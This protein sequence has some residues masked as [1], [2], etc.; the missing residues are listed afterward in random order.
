[1]AAVKLQR[2]TP[3]MDNYTPGSAVA[4]GAV[5]VIGDCPVI[6]TTDLEASVLGAVAIRGGVWRC[7]KATNEAI[8]GR[9]RVYWKA[10]DSTVTTTAST[11]KVFGYSCPDGAT[12]TATTVE[13]E[14]FPFNDL[15]VS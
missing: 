10:S 11:H 15:D 7:N 6:A 5:T 1:M 12:E 14:F 3:V 8:A 9:T 13:V 2:G 4:E